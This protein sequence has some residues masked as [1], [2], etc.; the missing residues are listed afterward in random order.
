MFVHHETAWK[1]PA[2]LAASEKAAFAVLPAGLTWKV[3]TVT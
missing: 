1:S 2:A 3:G